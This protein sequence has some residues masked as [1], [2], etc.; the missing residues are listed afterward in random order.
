MFNTQSFFSLV[1]ILHLLCA[2]LLWEVYRNSKDRSARFWIYGCIAYACGLVLIICRPFLP[3]FFG[4]TAAMF[5]VTYSNILFG[6]SLS[7][8]AERKVQRRFE[9]EIGLVIYAC[10]FPLA[11]E[12]KLDSLIPTL[13]AIGLIFTS[14]WVAS[15]SNRAAQKL[16]SPYLVAMHFLFIGAAVAWLIRLPLAVFFEFTF[17]TDSNIANWGTLMVYMC[18]TVLVQIAYLIVRLSILYQERLHVAE[19][20]QEQTVEQMLSSLN[21]LAMARD[22]ETGNH[23]IRTQHY[24]KVLAQSLKEMGYY[25]D[26]LSE[27]KIKLLYKAAPLH[28]VG[29]VGISDSILLKPGRLTEEEW[30]TMKTHTLIGESVLS[31]AESHLDGDEDVIATAIQIA[32]GHHEKWDGT[33]YPRGL[34]GEEIPLAARIMSLADMYDALVSERVYKEKW[35]HEMA[36]NEILSKRG[37]QFDPLVVQAF[38]AEEEQFQKIAKRYKDV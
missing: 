2:G 13:S 30:V 6:Y 27:K 1:A 31:S 35:T 10:L 16:N 28:D 3:L 18:C 36:A 12:A 33:G 29:K 26:S 22:N 32:G 24:V 4:F 9:F 7:A 25:V 11:L 15:V 19:V 5:F 20:K 23:I 17:I 14:L 21:A 38:I 8:L 37:I 34:K